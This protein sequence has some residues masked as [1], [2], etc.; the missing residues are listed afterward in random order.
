M[1]NL[2]K[3]ETGIA[4]LV[5]AIIIT[6][7]LAIGG[8]AWYFGLREGGRTSTSESST[9]D[10]TAPASEDLSFSGG[11]FDAIGRGRALECNWRAPEDSVGQMQAGQGKLYTDGNSR[12][13]SEAAFEINGAT[14][15]AYAIFTKDT[16]YN[17]A[18]LPS[19][20]AIGTKIS[21][22]ALEASGESLTEEQRRQG[23]AFSAK[24]NFDCKPW[25]VD[26]AK[27]TPPEDVEFRET[28][29]SS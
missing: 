29:S 6:L 9:S 23:A 11:Y 16:V 24:Y 25:T 18:Q 14:T 19:G 20:T 12:G 7:V 2:R 26:E 21:R 3:D 27:F 10:A 15:G 5:V 4:P 28:P 1:V 13:R 22:S 17:W 8:S